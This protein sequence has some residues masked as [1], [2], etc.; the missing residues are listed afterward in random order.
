MTVHSVSVIFKRAISAS[1]LISVTAG[2]VYQLVTGENKPHMRVP[3]Q[4]RTIESVMSKFADD[5]E[6]GM[7]GRSFPHC[8]TV[9]TFLVFSDFN[10]V[11]FFSTK[12]L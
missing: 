9:I 5:I 10:F 11:A 8:V 3:E 2:S 7:A 1:R 6:D 4:A 12:T